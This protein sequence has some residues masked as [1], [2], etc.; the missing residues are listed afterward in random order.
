MSITAETLATAKSDFDRDG[1]AII[2]GFLSRSDVRELE[3]QTQH[4]VR[5]ELPHQP[6]D[7]AFYEDKK[8]PVFHFHGEP[9]QLTV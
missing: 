7:A 2:R 5:E 3:D 9:R 1:Y 4:Y 6:P 8:R